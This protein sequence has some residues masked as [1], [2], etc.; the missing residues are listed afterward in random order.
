MKFVRWF[1]VVAVLFVCIPLYA[2]KDD[3]AARERQRKIIAVAESLIADARQLILPENRAAVLASTG[4]R[5]WEVDQKRAMNLFEDAVSELLAAQAEAE[6]EHKK[7]RQN[8]LL[9]GGSTRPS[10]LHAIAARNADFALKSLYRTR[11]VSIERFLTI[12]PKDTKIRTLSG[13]ETHL[14]Q[15]ELG[16]EQALLKLAADQ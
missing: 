8:E 3:E 6:I 2:Q 12:S 10:V 13:N 9:T 14:A 1:P 4:S 15:N 7:G 16:L 5:L 11:P